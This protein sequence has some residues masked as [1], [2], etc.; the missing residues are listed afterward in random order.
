MCGF[1][2]SAAVED[3]HVG[4]GE[5]VMCFTPATLEVDVTRRSSLPAWPRRPHLRLLYSSEASTTNTA[6]SRSPSTPTKQGG[7]T[8][9]T[10]VRVR[11]LAPR[12]ATSF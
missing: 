3:A 12:S 5:G 6:A 4:D 1:E 11:H 10:L 7:H 8:V 9:H 2:D